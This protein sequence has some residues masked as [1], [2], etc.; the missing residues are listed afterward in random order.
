MFKFL[1]PALVVG[2]LGTVSL[3]AAPTSAAAGET[4]TQALFAGLKASGAPSQYVRFRGGRRGL[5]RGRGF[6]RGGYGGGRGYGY[7]GGRGYG[8]RR[9]GGG[10]GAALGGLT[11]GALI[12][13]AI[14]SSQAARGPASD[15]GGDANAYCVRRFKSY[16]PGSGTYL[17][18]DGDRHSCP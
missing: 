6:G 7:R 13:G 17:G 15:D 1:L 5:G 9:G 14:S 3:G 8:Y 12:G 16:D 2:A 18:Y 10:V 11:A 4:S